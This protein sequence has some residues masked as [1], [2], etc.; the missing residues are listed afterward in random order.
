MRSSFTVLLPPGQTCNSQACTGCILKPLVSV[1]QRLL[2]TNWTS[3]R[4]Q[5][6]PDIKQ[7]LS[8]TTALT[9]LLFGDG[10]GAHTHAHYCGTVCVCLQRV[11]LVP[12]LPGS[13]VGVSHSHPQ[14]MELLFP[15]SGLP[16]PR[17]RLRSPAT[18]RKPGE[19]P[20]G[21]SSLSEEPV[22]LP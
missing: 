18:V 22:S 11:G 21:T 15:H 16:W 3:Q 14:V 19:G 10:D 9:L 12:E 17:A 1:L 20:G 5:R 2:K 4:S 6:A 7:R 13:P 8:T